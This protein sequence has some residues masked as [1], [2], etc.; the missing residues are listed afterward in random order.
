VGF[1]TFFAVVRSRQLFPAINNY[2]I[3]KRYCRNPVFT[4]LSAG[5]GGNTPKLFI[6]FGAGGGIRTLSP[7]E[8]SPALFPFFRAMVN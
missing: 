3:I 2:I 7:E 1:A 4:H 8:K 5:K 6:F